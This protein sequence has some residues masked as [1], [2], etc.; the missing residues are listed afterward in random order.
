[1]DKKIVKQI[2]DKIAHYL[3]EIDEGN[4]NNPHNIVDEFDDLFNK[5][6][7]SEHNTKEYLILEESA[8]DIEEEYYEW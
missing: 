6:P 1:M 3:K 4:Y 8:G 2:E 7:V 5:I